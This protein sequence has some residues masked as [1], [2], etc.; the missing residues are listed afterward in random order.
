MSKIFELYS[1]C[2]ELLFNA[3]RITLAIALVVMV[4]VTS[5]EVVRRYIFG[6][7]FVWAEELVKFLLVAITFLGGAAAYRAKG[8]AYLDLLTNKA[9]DKTKSILEIINS[10]II[11]IICAYLAV[12]GFMYTFSPIISKMKSTGLKL[13]MSIIYITIP[14]GFVL[15]SI[16]ALENIFN[17]IEER[18]QLT[19]RSITK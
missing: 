17:T 3:I 13:N 1:K 8:L 5:M 14:I 4:A 9:N 6:L 19:G 16:F 15:I 11:I 18:K 2:M 12:Q 7:S 10:L